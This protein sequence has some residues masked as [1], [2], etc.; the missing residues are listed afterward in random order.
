[1]KTYTSYEIDLARRHQEGQINGLLKEAAQW[2]KDNGINQ[3]G[4]L[5]EGGEDGEI[6]Q[7]IQNNETYTVVKDKEIIGTFTL[8]SNQNEWDEHVFGIE[9]TSDLLY[10]HRLA[11]HPRYMGQGIG[12]F[13]LDWIDGN[14]KSKSFIKLDCVAANTKLNEFYKSYGFE[15]LGVTRDGHS[16]Y[17]KRMKY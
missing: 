1:M 11:V 4:Y 17:Q 2:M 14:V 15:L 6:L 9:D 8:S 3:W 16:K 12:R 13:I 5:L 10:L 7:S